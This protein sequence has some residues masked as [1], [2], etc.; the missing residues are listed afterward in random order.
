[1]PHLDCGKVQDLGEGAQEK[2]KKRTAGLAVLVSSV[3]AL[4]GCTGLLWLNY[5]QS[6]KISLED[7]RTFRIGDALGS[8]RYCLENTGSWIL[9]SLEKKKTVTFSC[10]TEGERSLVS[11]RVPKPSLV[12]NV[13]FTIPDWSVR[14]D[15][16]R[17]WYDVDLSGG[18]DKAG[19]GVLKSSD[20]HES[21]R[22]IAL[23]QDVDIPKEEFDAW[24]AKAKAYLGE[25]KSP[26]WPADP[27]EKDSGS[28]P[29]GNGWVSL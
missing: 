26:A 24:R 19:Q 25:E 28:S 8:Y 17:V 9:K 11:A 1:M 21:L 18:T 10:H 15:V 4:G 23:G 12:L 5:V 14:Y 2:M 16:T 22:E 13:E 20:P 29:D 6:G 7:G 3:L 27:V